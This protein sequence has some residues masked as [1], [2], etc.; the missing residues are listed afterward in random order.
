M[1][2]IVFVVGPTASGKSEV[3]YLLASQTYAEIISADSMLIYREPAVI[4]AKP[5]FSMLKAVKHHFIGQISVEQPYNV[6]DYYE[7]ARKK[8]FGLCKRGVGVIVCGGSGLYVKVLCDGIFEGAG[9]DES[10]RRQL[11]LRAE[12]EGLDALYRELLAVDPQ[13]A[14]KI[15]RNDA[16]RIIRAL[17][18]YQ[19]SGVPISQKQKQIKGLCAEFPLRIFGLRLKRA[20]LYERINMR[21]EKMFKQGAVDEVKA[22][23]K[24]SLSPNAQKIIGLREI[25]GFL[26]GRYSKEEALEL[27][28]KNTRN[29][30]KRQLTWFN[31][32]RRVIWIDVD[33]LSSE[34]VCD[35]ILRYVRNN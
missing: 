31:K 6:F 16:R 24:L 11:R 19:V 30:A 34:E 33:G 27:M 17:E 9:S 18:V 32:D 3:A 12:K 26:D 35:I 1:K 23:R 28:K 8:I 4:T 13:A 5:S 2:P 20:T 7:Q 10:V 14:R 15:S 25:G 22:L 29:F 21:A